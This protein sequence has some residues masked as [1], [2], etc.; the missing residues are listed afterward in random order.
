VAEQHDVRIQAER[1]ER[2]LERAAGTARS[3]SSNAP[4]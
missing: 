4:T 1:I 3:D 2:V